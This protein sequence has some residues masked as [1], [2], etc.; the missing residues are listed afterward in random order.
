MKSAYELAMERLE[1]AAP[2]QKLTEA[3]KARIADIESRAK[4]R[5][6]ER[7]LA[8]GDLI[9]KARAA[10]DFAA[11]ESL[12]KQLV[13]ERRRIHEDAEAEKKRVRVSE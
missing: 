5:T 1:K 11:L 10:S 13:D 8:L 3:Q 2:T 4:A 9:A 6:A 12:E 7:E